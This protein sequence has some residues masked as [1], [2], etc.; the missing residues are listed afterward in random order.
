MPRPPRIDFPDALYHVTSRGNGRATIFHDEADCDLF[1]AQLA[2]HLRLADVQLFAYV[3]MGNHFH[4][5]VRTPRANLSRFMRRLLSSYALYSRYKHRRP[6]HLF[7]G[8]FRAKLI[9]DESY[10]LAV[11]RYIHLNPVKIAA[12]RRWSGAQRLRHLENYRWS[13]YPGHVA[14][15]N[16]QEFMR[17]EVLKE[18]G[19]DEAAARWHYRAYVHAC[20]TDDDGPLL[21]ALAANRFA[22]GSESFLEETEERIERRRSGE[23]RDRDLDL[24]RRAVS[25]ADIDAAVARHFK[26]DAVRLSQHGHRAGAAKAVAVELAVRLADL[27]GRAVGQHYGISSTGVGAIHRR[28]A[29]R[30]GVLVV[31]AK[32][33]TS[34][35]RRRRK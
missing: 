18:F 31:A 34:L 19:R 20:L 2:N 24:P 30:P 16:M 3:L 8:R 23:V 32:L 22:I 4:L 5:L 28:V 35:Q 33:A 11:S 17:Y 21:D 12:A 1:L 29:D 13:S 26:I 9:E 6:G 15:A 7:Q 27:S 10:L 25:L 14:K